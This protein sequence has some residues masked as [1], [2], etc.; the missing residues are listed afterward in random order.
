VI[1]GVEVD[2]CTRCGGT[3]FDPGEAP[4]VFGEGAHPEQW[5]ELWVTSQAVPTNLRCPKDA[6][7]LQAH[8]V[9][10]SGN[11]PNEWSLGPSKVVVDVCRHCHGMWLDQGEGKLL[12]TLVK[13]AQ[14]HREKASAGF[15]AAGYLF[16]LVTH[17]P[18]EVWNPVK[19]RPDVVRAL[20]VLLTACFLLELLGSSSLEE[21]PASWMLVPS[22]VLLGHNAWTLLTHGFLHAGWLHLIGNLYFL[23]IFGDNVEDRLGK[24]DFL[25]LYGAALVAGGVAHLLANMQSATPMLGASGAVAGVMGA[26]LLLFP[27]V[28][29][30]VMILVFRMRVRVTWYFGLWLAFQ[31]LMQLTGAERVAWMAHLGGFAAGALT[32]WWL[33]ARWAV[34]RL[35]RIS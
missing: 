7:G 8:T 25:I 2:H 11:M 1:E 17:V 32:A 12:H 3:F 34:G 20:V 5:R 16:Q 6:G 24:R 27:R 10:M 19:R 15:G 31:L 33:A 14:A 13:A 23:W 18:L 22:E 29:L 9:D 26:Y 28:Q 35:E 30:W 21:A 4:R